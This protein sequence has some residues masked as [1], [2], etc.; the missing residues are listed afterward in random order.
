MN[1]IP[2]AH[3]LSSPVAVVP[4]HLWDDIIAAKPDGEPLVPDMVAVDLAWLHRMETEGHGKMPGRTILAARWGWTEKR[5]RKA[6]D[7]FR[8]GLVEE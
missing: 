8:A 6:L 3:R 1:R 2:K 4:A 7:D 5:T